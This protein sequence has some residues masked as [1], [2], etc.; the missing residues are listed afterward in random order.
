[1]YEDEQYNPCRHVYFGPN[2]YLLSADDLARIDSLTSALNFAI[3]EIISRRAVRFEG[4]DIE[5]PRQDD[6]NT[7]V[8]D[9][10]DDP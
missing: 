4:E 8:Q 7:Q 10:I 5:T 1:M 9:V 2:H 6:F 3:T